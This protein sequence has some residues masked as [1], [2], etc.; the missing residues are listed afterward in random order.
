MR[1]RKP[2]TA[3]DG[4]RWQPL[5]DI[6]HIVKMNRNR[7]DKIIRVIEVNQCFICER[8]LLRKPYHHQTDCPQIY[9]TRTYRARDFG[10]VR[11]TVETPSTNLV[12]KTTLALL[13]IPSFSDTTMNCECEKCDRIIWPIFWV[14]DRSRAASTSSRMYIG[15]GLNSSSDRMSDR[16]SNER[17]P[18]LSSVKLSFHTPPKDTRT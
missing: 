3:E 6:L 11:V 1:H 12:R 17:W 16:A 5:G 13:N 8:I 15:A 18:P 7:C 9:R 10:T 4:G 2:W 14:C